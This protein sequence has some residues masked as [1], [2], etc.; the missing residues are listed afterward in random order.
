MGRCCARLGSIPDVASPPLALQ[1]DVTGGYKMDDLFLRLAMLC[2]VAE[3]SFELL[4]PSQSATYEGPPAVEPTRDRTSRMGFVGWN[5]KGCVDPT[6][7]V[8]PHVVDMISAVFRSKVFSGAH[9]ADP[10]Y[11]FPAKINQL[12]PSH[13]SLA[14]T[15]F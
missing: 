11:S 2:R 4:R 14:R 15:N 12:L 5:A 3:G 6:S 10:F 13:S 7:G 1:N 8:I 9:L